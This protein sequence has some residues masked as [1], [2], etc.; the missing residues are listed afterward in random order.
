MR[1]KD[2]YM[3]SRYPAGLHVAQK[4][5]H[6][7]AL[8]YVLVRCILWTKYMYIHKGQKSFFLKQTWGCCREPWLERT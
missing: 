3:L 2:C 7:S 1:Q 6:I 8:L 5:N 4:R